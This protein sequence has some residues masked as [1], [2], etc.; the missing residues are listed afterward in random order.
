MIVENLRRPKDST[1]VIGVIRGVIKAEEG[2]IKQYEKIVK[3]T[4]GV[5]F[6]TQDQV[7]HLLGDEQEHR[8]EFVG[9]LFEYESAE[10][11]KLVRNT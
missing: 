5:D 8:R 10:A 4:D 9:F 1:D 11:K 7:I 3:M 6:V 2:A